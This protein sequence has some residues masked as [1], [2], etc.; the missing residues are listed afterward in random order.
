MIHSIQ[1]RNVAM[2]LVTE[3][4]DSSASVS[5]PSDLLRIRAVSPPPPSKLE[6][7]HASTKPQG[8]HKRSLFDSPAP[9]SPKVQVDFIPAAALLDFEEVHSICE[10]IFNETL[11]IIFPQESPSSSKSPVKS[12]RSLAKDKLGI[13][14][15]ID[16]GQVSR[17]PMS[18]SD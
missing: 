2:K 4:R 15:N 1:K 14:L 12:L 10:H 5:T 9:G 6:F 7:S 13:Q 11:D 17:P 18:S 16:D 8:D 3:A